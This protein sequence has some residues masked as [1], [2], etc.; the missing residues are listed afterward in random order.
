MTPAT[1]IATF[2]DNETKTK[3]GGEEEDTTPVPVVEKNTYNHKCRNLCN[4]AAEEFMIWNNSLQTIFK[5][6]PCDNPES[7]FEMMDLMLYGNLK[8]T[9]DA[10][11]QEHIGQII[12]RTFRKK[13]GE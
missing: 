11:M 1:P 12:P 8:D 13:T 2:D 6:K 5:G 7:K 10:I 4:G 9:W 3:A